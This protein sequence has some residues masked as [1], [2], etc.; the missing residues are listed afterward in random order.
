MNLPPGDDYLWDRRGH[1]AEVERLEA[2]LAPLRASSASHVQQAARAR[3]PARRRTG[4]ALAAASLAIALAGFGALAWR[5]AWPDGRA[6]TVLASEG[7]AFVDE[8]VVRAG[9]ALAPGATLRTA[10]D[11]TVQLGVA[12]IGAA[13]LG[14]GSRLRI[15]RTRGGEHRVELVEGRLWARVWAPPRHFGVRLALA[16]VLD[17]GC[18]FEVEAAADGSGWLRVRSGWVAVEAGAREVLVP[19][20]ARV[21]LSPGGVPSTPHD[22]RASDAFVAA[23]RAADA[24][25]AALDP[26]GDEIRRLLAAARPADAISLVSLL[27]R[28]PRLAQGPLFD[29]LQALWPAAGPVDRAAVSKGSASALEPWWDALPYPRVKRWWLHWRDALPA[30][31]APDGDRDASRG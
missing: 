6:W 15:A 24:H 9:D 23:L 16:E 29:H 19:A 31:D 18:E 30:G 27:G 14:P 7:G 25:G 12:R 10:A 3:V 11:A 1:D 28:Q 4:V 8:R 17:L 20:G 22:E 13:R 5:L 2:L 21:V 26:A